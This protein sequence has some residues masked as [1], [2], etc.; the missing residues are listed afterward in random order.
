MLAPEGRRHSRSDLLNI[1]AKLE[2]TMKSYFEALAEKFPAKKELFTAFAEE[3]GEHIE[4]V[5]SLLKEVGENTNEE[6]NI[7]VAEVMNIFEQNEVLLRATKGIRMTKELKN[8]GEAMSLSSE[9][10][11]TVELFYCQ[12][13]ASFEPRDR[14]I[15]YD[16]IVEEH[17]HR[18]QDEEMTD[19]TEAGA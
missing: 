17:K 19:L 16:L 12:I 4:L 6:E 8:V 3:E 11:R 7:R 5:A 15:L 2:S 13:V 10:E 9:L 14:K 18:L 1:A